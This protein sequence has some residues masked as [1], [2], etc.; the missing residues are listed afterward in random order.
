MR[1]WNQWAPLPL[2]LIL[3]FGFIYHGFPKLSSIAGHQQF[4]GMLQGMGIPSPNVMAWLV[5]TLEVVGGLALILGVL[6]TFM[7]ALLTI[8]M[9]VALWTVHLPHGFSFLN[10]TG[11]TESGPTFGMPGYE[12]NLLYIAGLLALI[13]GGAG[14]YSL[15]RRRFG[16]RAEMAAPTTRAESVQ[17]V[18]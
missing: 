13:L 15:D 8:N 9:L 11:M 17:P 3:G 1:H 12:V 10:I 14:A 16:R 2:R 5:A 4:A 7:S 6:V 18:R